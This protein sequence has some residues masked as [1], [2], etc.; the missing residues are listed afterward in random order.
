MASLHAALA[1]NKSWHGL[2]IHV[3]ADAGT[4][5]YSLA[6]GVV[7]QAKALKIGLGLGF[8]NFSVE[9]EDQRG[10]YYVYD[11][12][13][14]LGTKKHTLHIQRANLTY[15][16]KLL[17]N[18][19]WQASVN[20]NN[21]SGTVSAALTQQALVQVGNGWLLNFTASFTKWGAAKATDL[22]Q[23]GVQKKISWQQANAGT[24]TLALTVFNDYNNDGL[25]QPNDT[26]ASQLQLMV[27]NLPLIT[28]EHG[29][30]F[31]KNLAK[32]VHTVKIIYG[33][34]SQ[35]NFIE[36]AITTLKNSSQQVGIPPQFTVAGKLDVVVS[37]FDL[38]SID[39]E[40]VHLAFLDDAGNQFSTFTGPNGVFTLKLPPANYRCILPDRK[41]SGN[42]AVASFA[43]DPIN[44]YAQQL[45]IRVTGAGG[46]QV[47]IKTLNRK[48]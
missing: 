47:E 48:G 28:D 34:A 29:A 18:T 22:F 36:K 46:R 19:T 7:G 38:T 27:D 45:Q 41:A 23:L 14:Q 35:Q 31:V 3:N 25:R 5:Q 17:N 11:L 32:G 43:V 16:A 42:T 37:K 4:Y 8:N 20:V 1:I 30:V 39:L 13:G 24:V 26:V 33:N 10:P 21:N 40:G 44:G 12:L 15:N 2:R 9:A 6:P